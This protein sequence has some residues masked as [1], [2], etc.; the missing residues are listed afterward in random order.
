MSPAVPETWEPRL[1]RYLRERHGEERE[2]FSAGD[3]PCDQSIVIRSPDG[4]YSVF[5]YAFAIVDEAA[6]EVAVFTE[7]RGYHV[8]TLVDAEVE[9]LRSTDPAD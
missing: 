5:R 9:K 2:C 7:H 4:S 8:F 6:D 1:R 3:F